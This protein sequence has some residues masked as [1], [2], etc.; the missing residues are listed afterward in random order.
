VVI[1][2]VK[3]EEIPNYLP[4]KMFKKYTSFWDKDIVNEGY[5]LTFN[6]FYIILYYQ[7]PNFVCHKDQ[8]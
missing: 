5:F 6:P 3:L 2:K 7:S 8:I 1:R 4:I